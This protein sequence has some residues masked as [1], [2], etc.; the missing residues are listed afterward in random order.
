MGDVSVADAL[1][2]PAR[3]VVVEAPGGCGKTFQGAN[4]A[5]DVAPS[6]GNGRLLIL[7]HTN[8]ACDVF[9]GRTR[10]LGS[11][12]E[13]RTIDGLIGEIAGA[14]NKSIG[15]PADVGAWARREANGYAIVAQKTAVLLTQ[16]PMIAEY[17]ACRYPVIICDEHQDANAD[18]HAIVM[19]LH[20][21]GSR[22]RIFADPMQQ[23]FNGSQAQAVA[24]EQRWTDLK[25]AADHF[26]ELDQPHRWKDTQ[27]ELGEWTLR[28]RAALMAGGQVD[29]TAKLP[30]GLTVHYADNIASQHG[31]FSVAQ[32]LRAPIYAMSNGRSL[33]VLTG[34]NDTVTSLRAFF[35]R[36]L[37]IWEGH[38]RNGL[39]DLIAHIKVHQGEPVELA[40][41]TLSFMAAVASGFS[42][43]AFGNCLVT[44]V[45]NG[46]AAKRTGKPHLLQSIGRHILDAPNHQGVA[47]ALERLRELV[48]KESCFAGVRIHHPREFAEAIQLGK[49]EDADEGFAEI[50]RRRTHARPKLPNK[51]ISTIHKAKGLEFDSVMLILC[52]QKNFSNTRAS[53]A[54]LYVALSRATSK[55]MLVV[56]RGQSTLLLKI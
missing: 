33:L 24:S 54:K 52:D 49:F 37:P 34:H 31:G 14:Y 46:C 28:A 45:Q 51:A 5:R 39:A 30:A 27:P 44:E 40:R 50:A 15:L 8:A 17:L 36:R 9:A 56:S 29:L 1:R 11:R 22:L 43:S 38:V 16:N 55:L 42:P 6:L 53:R 4:Y 23:I 13:I 48:E 35:G 21:A 7:T 20:A 41:A 10:G 47:R 25:N 18:Q 3:L 12:V 19:S 2:S 26:D 32:N